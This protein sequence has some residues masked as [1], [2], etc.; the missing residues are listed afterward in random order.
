MYRAPSR[1]ELARMMD[2]VKYVIFP[3]YSDVPIWIDGTQAVLPG[4]LPVLMLSG[5][6]PGITRYGIP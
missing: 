2:L 1:N 6:L 4:C 5:M 3:D